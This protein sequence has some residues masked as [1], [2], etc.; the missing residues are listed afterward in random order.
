LTSGLSDVPLAKYAG[1]YIYYSYL[2]KGVRIYE[3]FGRRLHAKTIAIDDVYSSVG[4]FNLDLWSH[5]CNLELVLTTLGPETATQL[6]NQF[7]KDLEHA[8]EVSLADLGQRSVFVRIMHFVAYLM[9]LL[10][11]KAAQFPAISGFFMPSIRR[12][13]LTKQP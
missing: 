12:K 1:Q 6:K 5:Q 8:N 11:S 4:S 7:L 10:Q 3:H 13:V 2:S 9:L